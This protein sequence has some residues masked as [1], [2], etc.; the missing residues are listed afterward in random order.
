MNDRLP[1]CPTVPAPRRET[2]GQAPI[3][4]GTV[5]GTRAGQTDLKALAHKVLRAG[6]GAGQ[7]R[8][9]APKTPPEVCPT[10]R[11]TGTR[12]GT[13]GTLDREALAVQ[14]NRLL[15]AAHRE[16][17]PRA[18]ID[19]LDDTDIEGADHWTDLQLRTAARWYRDDPP[20]LW[21]KGGRP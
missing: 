7:D 13:A 3:L 12:S 6:Q 19:C 4:S 21:R 11:D 8:D 2:A 14:R 1:I 18:V 5:R 16:G 15:L 17:I 20:R 10:D 9:S